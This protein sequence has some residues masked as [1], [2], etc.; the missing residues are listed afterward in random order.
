LRIAYEELARRPADL[1]AR[2][3]SH[4]DLAPSPRVLEY[5]RAT[6]VIA[7]PAKTEDPLELPPA[8]REAFEFV[9]GEL[10]YG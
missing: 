1:F 2:V 6:S 9:Q 3:L 7:P 8:L 4:C 10:G 5:A